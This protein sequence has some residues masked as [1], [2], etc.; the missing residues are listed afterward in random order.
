MVIER[1]G[2][3]VWSKIHSDAGAPESF[4]PMEPYSDSVTFDLVATTCKQLSVEPVVIL[5]AF[6]EY[7]VAKIASVQY[8]HIMNNSGVSF[9]DF[10][11]NLD[12]MHQR[13]RVAFPAYDPPSFRVKP[14]NDS[15]VQVDYY[16]RREGL[17]PFVE[18]LLQ[19]LAVR[20]SVRI[21]IEHV[22]GATHKLP[23]KRMVVRHQPATKG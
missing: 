14:L 12:H 19:G 11:G 20:F 3:A 23:C 5:R 10:L 18:G 22:D 2:H 7:W 1:Y 13:I 9:T 17:L 21:E 16:S 15:T 4:L 8:E 6:G